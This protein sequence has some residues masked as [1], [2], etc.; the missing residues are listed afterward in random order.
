MFKYLF[1]PVRV[2]LFRR[3]LA[4]VAIS[5]IVASGV[6]SQRP[7]HSPDKWFP[8]SEMKAARSGAGS[9]VLPD[10]RVLTIGGENAGGALYSV[11]AYSLNNGESSVAS[12]NFARSR[13]AVASL[14]DGHV[15]VAGG[16][17]LT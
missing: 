5:L 17:S 8:I 9:A 6:L 3:V 4:A 13:F 1:R 2:T 7:R 10:G 12:M 15:L 11:E 16:T 14:A